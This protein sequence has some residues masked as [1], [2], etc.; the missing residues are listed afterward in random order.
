MFMKN[1]LLKHLTGIRVL[2]IISV[3][4]DLCGGAVMVLFCD[5]GPASVCIR[6]GG[7]FGL[8]LPIIQIIAFLVLGFLLKRETLNPLQTT[9]AFVLALVSVLSIVMFVGLYIFQIVAGFLFMSFSMT[10][11]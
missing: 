9:L 5:S 10:S 3:L 4:I 7:I 2:L 8:V 6:N 1:F 11:I